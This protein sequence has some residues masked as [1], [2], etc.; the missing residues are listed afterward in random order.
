MDI[1]LISSLTADDENAFAPA[2]LKAVGAIL[3][4]FPIAYTLRVETTGAQVFQHTHHSFET[5]AS[6]SIPAG[7]TAPLGTRV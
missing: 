6:A 5:A 7:I 3:D 1:R 2:L 4:Q